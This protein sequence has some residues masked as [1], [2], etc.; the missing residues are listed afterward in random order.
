[1]CTSNRKQGRSRNPWRDSR[2]SYP[3]QTQHFLYMQKETQMNKLLI[4]YNIESMR[5]PLCGFVTEENRN[6]LLRKFEEFNSRNSLEKDFEYYDD[7]NIV[8]VN[9]SK[10]IEALKNP[11]TID[12]TKVS[13]DIVNYDPA[14][15]IAQRE[16]F[17]EVREDG[18]LH[19]LSLDND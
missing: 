19:E 7:E 1:M 16:K 13:K 8:E 15:Y 2:E 3:M 12:M 18:T 11:F 6:I 17:I 9:C 5:F 4:I 14:T 10:I